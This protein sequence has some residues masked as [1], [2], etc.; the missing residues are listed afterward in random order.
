MIDDD[1]EPGSPVQH[2]LLFTEAQNFRIYIGT[3]ALQSKV[4]HGPLKTFQSNV[5]RVHELSTIPQSVTR[6]STM[7]L[8][9]LCQATFNVL[10]KPVMDDDEVNTHRNAI[11]EAYAR[12]AYAHTR[13]D[14]YFSDKHKMVGAILGDALNYH[15]YSSI[16][17][18]TWRGHYALLASQIIGAWTAL[19]LLIQDTWVAVVN[20]HP[21][22][23]VYEYKGRTFTV[24]DLQERDF[25]WKGCVGDLLKDKMEFGH[26]DKE[27]KTYEKIFPNRKRLHAALAS[28]KLEAAHSVRNALIHDSGLA[29]TGFDAKRKGDA[30]KQVKPFHRPWRDVDKGQLLPLDGK[31]VARLT[32]IIVLTGNRLLREVDGWLQ[33]REPS[34][35]KPPDPAPYV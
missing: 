30:K 32:S 24:E 19:E 8:L 13:S 10:G 2:D 15:K 3:P 29:N 1:T 14:G 23:A 4:L 6:S 5:E 33:K 31:N 18:W 28:S 16:L 20:A 12:I 26:L 21:E 25:N 9:M 35:C 34:A 17:V 7:H 27:R 11:A 22:T